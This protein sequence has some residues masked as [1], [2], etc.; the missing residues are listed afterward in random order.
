MRLTFDLWKTS[1]C[2]SL[3][4]L[5]RGFDLDKK[6]QLCGWLGCGSMKDVTE[7]VQR[8]AEHT[9]GRKATS[10]L[11]VVTSYPHQGLINTWRAQGLG[12]ELLFLLKGKFIFIL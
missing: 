7:G 3:V 4:D 9:G 1:A 8:Q 10:L 5:S 12:A 2:S 11:K 6:P